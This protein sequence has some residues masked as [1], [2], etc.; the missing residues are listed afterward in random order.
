MRIDAHQHFWRFDPVRDS[1]I[2]ADMSAIA[3]DFMPQDLEPVLHS[4]GLDGTVAVQAAESSVETDF[5]LALA[6]EHDWIRSVVGWLDPASADVA[7]ELDRLD[8][9]TRLAGFRHILQS[10]EPEVMSEPAFRAGI[11]ALRQRDYTFDLLIHPRHLPAAIDLVRA[12]PDQRFVID[13]LAKPPIADGMDDGWR[14]D[15]RTIARHE[16]VF[17]KI[18]GMVTEADWSHWTR[19]QFT[20]FLDTVFD[21]FGPER[22][23]YGSDWPVCLLAAPAGSV[24]NIVDHYLAPFSAD[25]QARVRGGTAC[26]FYGITKS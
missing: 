17:C 14:R 26:D 22:L 12:C 1:W 19:E 13:H 6:R 21:C 8:G 7:A 18:S 5:L 24:M 20:P 2:D 16:N 10:R 15:I 3:R 4:L 25:E 11:R 23:M 9:E